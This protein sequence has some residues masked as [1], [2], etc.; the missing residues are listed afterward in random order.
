MKVFKFGGAC[1]QYPEA[2][3]KLEQ[4]IKSE[5]P[6]PLV[7]VVSAMGKTT[8]GLEKIFQQRLDA[9]PYDE[10][11]QHLYLFH[12]EMID[13]LLRKLR[14]E[15]YQ[16]LAL[17][18]EQLVTTLSVPAVDTSLE[19][20]YS[21]I[22]AEG[23]LLA[24]KIIDYYLQEQNVACAWLDARRCIKTN[25]RFCNAQVDWAATKHWVKKNVIPLLE[26]NQVVLTQ[27]FIGSNEAGETTTLGKEGSDFT[28][29]ILA[30]VLRAQSLTIWKDVPGI[31][32]ADPKLFKQ[33]T[34]FDHISYEAMAEMAFYGAKVLHPK[35]IQPLAA[36][37]IPL[38]V[39]P[40][41]RPHEAGTEITH[42]FP[43]LEHPVYIL[44]KNQGLVHL[45]REHPT[46]FDEEHLKE[47]FHQLTQH[48]TRVNMLAK[49]AHTFSICLNADSYRIRTLLAALNQKFQ[50]HYHTP[51]NLL[52]IMHQDD[53]LPKTLLQQETILL[54]QQRPGVY[55]A[56]FQHEPKTM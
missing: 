5:Q 46:F 1:I 23:E 33:A 13:H 22:V 12:Q 37:N 43:Q 31:M 21:R 32:S 54:G 14:Q 9:Q 51:V 30:A 18:K 26:K 48:N 34:K 15:A 6:H 24:S 27:G 3:R 16:T 38:Y 56:V 45:S 7:I 40:F 47:V 10:T 39:K 19:E 29:A 50:V 11:L 49:S 35:T 52:T 28:G 55:Q 4:F 8:K 42:G 2:V 41:H 44:Q 25:S 20:L 53:S 17:W 36:H